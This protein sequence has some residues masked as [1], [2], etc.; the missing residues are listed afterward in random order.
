MIICNK[1]EDLLLSRHRAPDHNNFNEETLNEKSVT[2]ITKN[3]NASKKKPKYKFIKPEACSRTEQ[4]RFK[5]S[6]NLF[7]FKIYTLPIPNYQESSCL[8]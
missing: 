5:M 3:R 1:V 8:L 2:H 4:V 7:F 6:K